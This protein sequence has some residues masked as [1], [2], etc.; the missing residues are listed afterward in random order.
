MTNIHNLS[1]EL[2]MFG[3]FYFTATISVFARFKGHISPVSETE[4]F[5]KSPVPSCGM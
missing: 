2:Q 1:S 5:E 4:E 3:I